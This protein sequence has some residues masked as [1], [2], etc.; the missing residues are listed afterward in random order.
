[1]QTLFRRK[2]L[3]ILILSSPRNRREHY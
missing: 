3:L 1:M 2:W